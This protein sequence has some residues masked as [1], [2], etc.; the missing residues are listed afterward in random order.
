MLRVLYNSYYAAWSTFD[1]VATMARKAWR[2]CSAAP[3]RRGSPP[4]LGLGG[5]GVLAPLIPR[6]PLLSATLAK[7][8]TQSDGDES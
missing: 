3:T 6:P 4:D 2:F 5:A 7:Q 8:L 1:I